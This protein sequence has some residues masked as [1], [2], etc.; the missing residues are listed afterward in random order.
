MRD[1]TDTRLVLNVDATLVAHAL[2]SHARSPRR[3]NP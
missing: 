2:A 1:A 3:T